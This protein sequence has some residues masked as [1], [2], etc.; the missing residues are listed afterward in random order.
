MGSLSDHL[1]HRVEQEVRSWTQTEARD[2]YV[3]ALHIGFVDDDMRQGT[4]SGPCYNPWRHW[5]AQGG[6]EEQKWQAS[7][8]QHYAK[9]TSCEPAI[10]EWGN[11]DTADPVG[12][13][14]RNKHLN[15]MSLLMTDAEDDRLWKQLHHKN[16]QSER[17]GS[18]LFTPEDAAEYDTLR[19]KLTN[20]GKAFVDVC[21]STVRR[22]HDEGLIRE[23]CGRSVPVV[24]DVSNDMDALKARAW[25]LTREVNPNGVAEDW[26]KAHLGRHGLDG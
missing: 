12:V 16:V 9:S 21:A 19:E 26:V 15:D 4:V 18:S 7:R 2:I 8:Y 10:E 22:L 11:E 24:L 6:A 3:I 13:D 5:Q 17:L 23:V 25:R 20:N 14:L 1:Y